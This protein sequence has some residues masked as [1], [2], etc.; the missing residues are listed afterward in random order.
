MT[1]YVIIGSGI[2]GLS[3]AKAIRK[4]DTEGKITMLTKEQVAPYYRT[5]L[6]KAISSG[7]TKEQL[8]V[9]KEGFYEENNIELRLSTTVD[10]VD[11]KNNKVLLE[12]GE[13]VA[14][15]KL[16]IASGASPFVPPFESENQQNIFKMRTIEDLEELRRAL[17]EIKTALVVGG[18]LLGLEAAQA[19]HEK[20]VEVH[21]VEFADY[22][23]VRQLDADTAKVLEDALTKEGFILHTKNSLKKVDGDGKVE[24]VI[25]TD[26]T[27]FDCQAVLFSVGVRSDLSLACETLEQ[28]RGLVVNNELKSNQDNVWVAGDCAEVSGMTMGLW[29]ASMDMGKIA[30]E[31]M[32]GGMSSYDTP[33]LFTNLMIGDIKLFS[34]GFN[35]S[36]DVWSEEADG[37]IKKLF[38]KDGVIIGGILYKDTKKMGTINKLLA[39]KASKEEAIEQMK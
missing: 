32:T 3:A 10:K 16:L 5:K 15:D 33:K 14:Y 30:G 12:N 17:P 23:L 39:E 34:A 38:F 8:L 26:G 36:E 37:A 27:S 1:H 28:N 2:A 20:G 13:E 19:L 25:M 9:E 11:Y 22:L 18:G 31:N 7:E 21:I 29:T 6:T 24:R 35:D 4:N